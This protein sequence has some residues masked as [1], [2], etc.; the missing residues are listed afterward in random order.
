MLTSVGQ[1]CRDVDADVGQNRVREPI[2]LAEKTNK[3]ISIRDLRTLTPPRAVARVFDGA[4]RARRERQ[5][6]DR[7]WKTAADRRLANGCLELGE[8]RSDSAQ[9]VR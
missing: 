6:L 9:R 1:H 3:K 4:D 7:W 8:A 2:A 5:R